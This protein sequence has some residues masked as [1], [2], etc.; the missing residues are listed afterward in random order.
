MPE[1]EE[2]DGPALGAQNEGEPIAVTPANDEPQAEPAIETPASESAEAAEEAEAEQI[3]A[4][5][6]AAHKPKTGSARLKAQRDEARAEAQRLQM[7]LARVS[8]QQAP[9]KPPPVQIPTIDQFIAAN[10]Q[11][12]YDDYESFKT[13]AIIEQAE[14]RAI[15]RYQAQEQAKRWDDGVAKAKQ[16][17]PD[18]DEVQDVQALI[19]AGVNLQGVMRDAIIR[20]DPAVGPK[21]LHYLAQNVSEARRIAGLPPIEAAVEL[22]ALKAALV[23]KP[24]S[25]PPLKTTQAPPPLPPARSTGA[26]SPRPYANQEDF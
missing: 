11:A 25:K 26:S 3:L 12:T 23:S 9:P 15:Q 2:M 22:G 6:E 4:E 19:R 20:M 10:P 5:E 13:Q 21:V 14:Q 16:D 18:L 8:G 1:Y 24:T 7:E 17:I